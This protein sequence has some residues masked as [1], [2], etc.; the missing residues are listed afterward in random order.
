MY[1]QREGG[2]LGVGI[3]P[4]A[5]VALR[6]NGLDVWHVSPFDLKLTNHV[7][8]LLPDEDQQPPE[9]CDARRSKKKK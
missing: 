5:S 2:T 8:E 3:P 7:T 4:A 6:C 1:G 9:A